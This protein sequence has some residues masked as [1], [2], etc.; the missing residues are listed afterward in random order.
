MAHLFAIEASNLTHLIVINQIKRL[1]C[2]YGIRLFITLSI[3]LFTLYIIQY[4]KRYVI[5]FRQLNLPLS[6]AEEYLLR[7]SH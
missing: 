7:Y 1:H 4:S 5:R 2:F 3:V 6:S